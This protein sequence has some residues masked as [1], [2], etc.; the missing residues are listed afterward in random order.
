MKLNFVIDKNYL[1]KHT[2]TYAE[3]NCFSSDKNKKDILSFSK[4]VFKQS[5]KY[6]DFLVGV[7]SPSDIGEKGLKSFTENINDE[8]PKFL[9]KIKRSKEFKTIY[10]QTK[11]YLQLPKKQWEENLE[12]TSE[13][14]KELTEFELD[15]IFTVY[16]THPSQRNGSYWGDNTISWGVDE[17]MEE[18]FNYLFMA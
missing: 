11:T 13:I 18:L 15:K 5:P 1:I 12:T 8:L 10:S 3:N 17:K 16:I 2:L 14:I 4:Y 7:V 6:Y 9:D